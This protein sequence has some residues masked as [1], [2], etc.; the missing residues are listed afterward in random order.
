MAFVFQY[1]SNCN[2]R[3]L[4][5]PGRLNGGAKDLGRAQTVEMF[6]I[7][8]NKRVQSTG[9]AAADLIKPRKG[10][11][12]IWGV[13]Y[14]VSKAGFE[15]LRKIEGSSYRPQD[16]AVEDSDGLRKTVKTF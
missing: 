8:F 4:N 3:R 13:L 6:E 10:G 12:R 11:R 1:G 2:K 16:I 15:R 9:F 14:E 7:A 5:D